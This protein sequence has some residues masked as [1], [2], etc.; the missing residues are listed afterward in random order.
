MYVSGMTRF[1]DPVNTA[2]AFAEG[3]NYI[4]PTRNI[5]N[6]KLNN[7]LRYTDQIFDSLIGLENIPGTEG[8]RVEKESATNNRDVGA[9]MERVFG[10]RSVAPASNIQRLFNDV[11]RPQWQTELRVGSPEAQ[12]IVN[13]YVFPYLE[14]MA[15]ALFEGGRWDSLDLK[16]KQDTLQKLLGSEDGAKGAVRDMLK[17]QAPG[18]DLKKAELIWQVTG[19]RSRGRDNYKQTLDAFGI[20]ESELSDMDENQLEV[21]IWFIKENADAGGDLIDNILDDAL[22]R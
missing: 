20:S 2:L 9:G 4:E 7:A 10:V 22:G 11:G 1:A 16:T 5:G 6:K 13:E 19:L 21:L 12:N 8:Y 3:E 17:S 18:S 14:M 15:T